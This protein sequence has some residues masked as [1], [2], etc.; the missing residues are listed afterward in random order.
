MFQ[1]Y[2]TVHCTKH[3]FVCT[4]FGEYE[5]KANICYL[6]YLLISS[7]GIQTWCKSDGSK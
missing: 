7:C 3:I 1:V 5:T 2:L 6:T 4:G